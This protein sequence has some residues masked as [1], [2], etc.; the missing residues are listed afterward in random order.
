MKRSMT[1]EAGGRIL[2][3]TLWRKVINIACNSLCSSMPSPL[4]KPLETKMHSQ[5][6]LFQL[7]AMPQSG[8]YNR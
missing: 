4:E 7:A 2:T 1:R 3:L 6:R 5:N 8:A